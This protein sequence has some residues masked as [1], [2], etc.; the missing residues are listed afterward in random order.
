M[1][2]REWPQFGIFCVKL[3]CVLRK[4]QQDYETGKE[5]PEK[6]PISRGRQPG[7]RVIHSYPQATSYSVTKD[8]VDLQEN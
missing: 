1:E 5:I 8:S 2:A 7:Q 3:M 4:T 6:C